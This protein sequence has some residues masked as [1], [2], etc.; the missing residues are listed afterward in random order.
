MLEMDKTKS[1]VR[2]CKEM[3]LEF[4]NLKN[5]DISSKLLFDG[6]ENEDVYNIT[7][8]FL[9]ERKRYLAGKSGE[10][11]RGMVSRCFSL[12]RK[13]KSGLQI[14]QFRHYHFKIHL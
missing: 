11:N 7:A 4:K 14:I 8:P 9:F 5:R 12:W 6:I 13:M 3:L 1:N 10:T 2:T